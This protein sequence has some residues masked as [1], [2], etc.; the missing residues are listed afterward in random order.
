MRG[1]SLPLAFML[2][3]TIGRVTIVFSVWWKW[4]FLFPIVIAFSNAVN[5]S[6]LAPPI[7]THVDSSVTT[8]YANIKVLIFATLVF[9]R[10]SVNV[11]EGRL[12]FFASNSLSSAKLVFFVCGSKK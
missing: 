2:Y 7:K 8:S 11:L 1:V 6:Y 5:L 12:I 4:P 10:K 9:A 3:K